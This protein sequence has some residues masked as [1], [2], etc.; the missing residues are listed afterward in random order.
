[1]A[2][3]ALGD[4]GQQ[5]I[6][7]LRVLTLQIGQR[8]LDSPRDA[9]STA[10]RHGELQPVCPFLEHR[11]LSGIGP[12]AAGLGPQHDALNA[13]VRLEHVEPH[14]GH[15]ERSQLGVGQSGADLD[16]LAEGV[17]IVAHH[18]HTPA[19]FPQQPPLRNMPDQPGIEPLEV[20]FV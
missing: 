8:H 6:V 9:L 2:A 18:Q 17:A 16:G 5:R 7:S 11:K 10:F 13:P 15:V 4:P 12:K 1:M 3:R 14:L 19:R 20:A